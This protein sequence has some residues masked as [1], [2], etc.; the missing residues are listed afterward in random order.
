MLLLGLT[1]SFVLDFVHLPVKAIV[2]SA[3]NIVS[4]AVLLLPNSPLSAGQSA[5]D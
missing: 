5:Y 3:D 2:L 4:T 1:A